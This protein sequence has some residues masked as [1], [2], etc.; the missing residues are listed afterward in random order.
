MKLSELITALRVEL[1]NGDVDVIMASDEE[2]NS[3]YNLTDISRF[4]GDSDG[5]AHLCLWPGG[6]DLIDDI[7]DEDVW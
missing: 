4:D 6:R 5:D 2:G 1:D 3:F 7:Y